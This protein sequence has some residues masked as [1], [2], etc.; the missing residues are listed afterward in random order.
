MKNKFY[1][2]TSIAYTN[3]SPHIGY[4]L[5]LI[6]ADVTARFQRKKGKDVWFLTGT[7]EHGIKIALKAAE[8]NKSCI[9]FCDNVSSEF[10][11]LVEKLNISNNDFIRTTDKERHWPS[12]KEIW[13]Q[14]KENDD[15]YEKEYAGLYCFGCEAFIKETDLIDGK[16]PHHKREPEKISEK[17]YFFKLSKYQEQIEKILKENL[18]EVVPEKRKNEMISFVEKGLEDISFSRPKE[19]MKWGIPVPGDDSQNIYVWSDA[20]I[21]Y[22]SALSYADNKDFFNSC[23]PA[24]IHFIG[25]DIAKFHILIW[26]AI[27][28]SAKLELPKKIFIHGFITSNGQKMSKTIGNVVDPFDLIERYGV[29]AVRYYFLREIA[30]TEDGDYS[31]AKFKERYNSDLASGLGN[32]NSRTITLLNK[33]DINSIKKESAIVQK[34]IKE[35]AEKVEKETNSFKFNNALSEIWKLISFADKYIEEN[36]PWEKEKENRSQIV[37][38]LILIVSSVA[39]QLESF[40]PETSMKIKNQIKNQKAEPIFKRIE[41]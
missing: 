11:L 24:D 36:R 39:E 7:D 37:F 20:L 29:D 21:N 26:P 31:E 41:D 25:K 22:I 18:I 1:I 10:R 12:V 32:L 23:W 34:Q 8:E 19:K 38:D 2:T 6:Q 40:M 35:T 16:C 28:L 27:L 17:N 5:E 14:L 30:P 15:I 9:D 4:A 13:N 3:A 33:I